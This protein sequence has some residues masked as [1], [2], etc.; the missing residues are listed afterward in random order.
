MELISLV[1]FIK[2]LESFKGLNS[3]KIKE[4]IKY[5]KQNKSLLTPEKRE[6]VRDQ[7]IGHIQAAQQDI[8]LCLVHNFEMAGKK[9]I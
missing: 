7:L 2:K 8:E 1:Q 5:C 3:E 9:G 6:I 4:I